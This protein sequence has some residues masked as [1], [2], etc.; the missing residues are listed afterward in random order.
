MS[1]VF[2]SIIKRVPAPSPDRMY[3]RDPSPLSWS[4]WSYEKKRRCRKGAREKEGFFTLIKENSSWDDSKSH[5]V[6]QTRHELTKQS[7]FQ[8]VSTWYTVQD[9]GSIQVLHSPTPWMHRIIFQ[10]WLP[11]QVLVSPATPVLCH[12]TFVSQILK[13]N[14][15]LMLTFSFLEK[16]PIKHSQPAVLVVNSLNI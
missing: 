15:M 12:R 10:A 14:I 1:P 6:L 3:L 4:E 5:R 2:S 7:P 16:E 13:K 8:F 9:V 11:W